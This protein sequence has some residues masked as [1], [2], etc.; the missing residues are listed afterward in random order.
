VDPSGCQFNWIWLP[1]DYIHRPRIDRVFIDFDVMLEGPKAPRQPQ[2]GAK[3]IPPPILIA[4]VSF[5][6]CPP[7]RPKTPPRLRFL[8][9]CQKA[10]YAKNI[11]ETKRWARNCHPVNTI[12][13]DSAHGSQG[14][15]TKGSSQKFGNPW[16]QWAPTVSCR[17]VIDSY[18]YSDTKMIWM[19]D[20]GAYMA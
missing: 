4:L 17:L 12:L 20:V 19:W 7:N 14:F 5:A 13:L 10:L 18:S 8:L 6:S 15:E 11:A 9:N 3:T 2:G 1:T 16:Y